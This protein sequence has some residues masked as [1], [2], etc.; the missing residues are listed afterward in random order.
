MELVQEKHE[1][2]L[3]T[4][5]EYI[6]CTLFSNQGLN[7]VPSQSFVIGR[8]N[9]GPL[10]LH[11]LISSMSFSKSTEIKSGLSFPLM[12]YSSLQ[13]DVGL[14]MCGWNLQQSKAADADERIIR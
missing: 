2:K 14:A 9:Y 13:R 6:D 4:A 12:Q 8:V 7:S 3:R 5:W 10:G 1:R 11:A